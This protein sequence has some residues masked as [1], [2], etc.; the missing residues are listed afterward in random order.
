MNK[1]EVYTFDEAEAAMCLWEECLTRLA[2][3]R[4]VD[5]F[6]SQEND[7][8]WKFLCKGEGAACARETCLDLAK[9]LAYS[10]DYAYTHYGYCS[11]FDW[12]FVPD[13]VDLAIEISESNEFP[14]QAWLEYMAEK[15]TKECRT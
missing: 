8:Y 13:W 3:A 2:R 9:P 14:T 5:G 15:I 10:Y 1:N 6:E 12:E 11:S 7:P 4:A